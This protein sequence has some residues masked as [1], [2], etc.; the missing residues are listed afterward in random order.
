[1]KYKISNEEKDTCIQFKKS[2]IPSIFKW[3]LTD[4]IL[5]V[6]DVDSYVCDLLLKGK[7]ITRVIYDDI[8]A[9]YKRFC[10]NTDIN[11]FDEYALNYYRQ[12]LKVMEIF[13]KYCSP[14]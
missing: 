13:E 7:E 10:D 1:M 14:K 12:C 8:M 9:D 5:F 3:D 6:E 2:R 11:E 4:R